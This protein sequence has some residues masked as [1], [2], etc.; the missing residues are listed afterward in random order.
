[1]INYGAP[2]SGYVDYKFA[3]IG[4]V[5]RERYLNN[6]YASEAMRQSANDLEAAPFEGDEAMRS[7]L[8]GATDQTLQQIADK[9]DY[10]NMT[11]AVSRASNEF[12][13]K[14][15]PIAQ[16][17]A[18]YNDY[19][20]DLK[21]QY[22][23]GKIDFEDY[24][25]NLALST[26]NYKGL[27]M[28]EAGNASKFFSGLDAVQNPDINGM[29]KDALNGMKA[30]GQTIV[31]RV[32]GQGPDGMLQV[33]TE[34]GIE[35]VD[36]SRVDSAMRM[37]MEDP[38][39]QSYIGRKA[40]IRTGM[41]DDEQVAGALG[42]NVKAV[43]KTINRI[44]E[45][46]ADASDEEREQLSGQKQDLL[47]NVG[48]LK[49]LIASGDGDKMRAQ[50]RSMEANKINGMYTQSAR[51]RYSY[52][53]TTDK[54]K[55]DYDKLFLIDYKANQAS[56]DNKLVPYAPSVSGALQSYESP[57]GKSISSKTTYLGNLNNQIATMKEPGY[58]D[59]VLPGMTYD[60]IKGM[61]E[62]QYIESKGGNVPAEEV[63]L[64]R[65]QRTAI[66]E[67]EGEKAAMGRL[68]EEAGEATG[69]TPEARLQR[70][71]N[72]QGV[73]EALEKV[74]GEFPDMND[75][76]AFELFK[77][78]ANYRRAGYVGEDG[79]GYEDSWYN[80]WKNVDGGA[81]GEFK[82]NTDQAIKDRLFALFPADG[83]DVLLAREP[84]DKMAKAIFEQ[85]EE[86]DEKLSEYLEGKSVRQYTPT[87]STSVPGMTKGTQKE[88]DRL[89]KDSN[90]KQRGT[91]F[92][93]PNTGKVVAF[94][95]L[96]V[97]QGYVGDIDDAKDLMR[98]AQQ[99]GPI[100]YNPGNPGI[101]GGTAE[102]TYQIQDGDTKKTVTTQVPF[103][104]MKVQGINEYTQGTS[105]Q[106]LRQATMQRSHGVEKP[107]VTILNAGGEKIRVAVD[108]DNDTITMLNGPGRTNVPMQMGAALATGGIIATLG[109]EGSTIVAN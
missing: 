100:M 55:E 54:Y 66:L 91:A 49:E 71:M 8:L 6:F 58:F 79:S 90:P 78:F 43:E 4:D 64:F 72:V 38:R 75:Y 27:E 13:K 99:I 109:D 86:S 48:E 95:E 108:Y 21:K 30:D 40:E 9:G 46:M 85:M 80:T 42:E 106:F 93:S 97:E 70:A 3:E 102:V 31:Q 33:E 24:Q 16:N 92:V 1:M 34:R 19:K 7:Q 47:E 39:V 36:A 76:E 107:V 50:A 73:P 2:V 82:E 88:V 22:E 18:A 41:M 83:L 52:T 35:T 94:D 103:S 60:Q 69:E 14:A 5:R 96:L 20:A 29:L 45:M 10:E 101:G 25:G 11:L 26:Y 51:D 67:V 32:V 84:V 104:H 15:K 105:Y 62:A 57:S 98:T 44:D 56:T 87:L 81:A 23:E 68:L 37:V 28:D 17:A 63:A 53:K 12:Q 59:D 65:Q 74:K 89:W 61:S 77:S